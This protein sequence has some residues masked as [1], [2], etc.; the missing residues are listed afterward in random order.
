MAS[1]AMTFWVNPN[2][3]SRFYWG[4]ADPDSGRKERERD[5]EGEKGTEGREG[6][7][8]WEG[9]ESE[10]GARE[11]QEGCRELEPWSK[12]RKI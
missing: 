12:E 2:Y 4:G 7:G 8:R 5:G 9:G 1:V 11:D 6:E 10:R 3:E